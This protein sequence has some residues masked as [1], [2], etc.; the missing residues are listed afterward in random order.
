MYIGDTKSMALNLLSA[1][2]IIS[3]FPLRLLSILLVHNT[4]VS[5]SMPIWNRRSVVSIRWGMACWLHGIFYGVCCKIAI[6]FIFDGYVVRTSSHQIKVNGK[7]EVWN[8]SIICRIFATTFIH[9]LTRFIKSRVS[10]RKTSANK[11]P[12][13]HPQSGALFPQ[14]HDSTTITQ[15]EIQ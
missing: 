15:Q 13:L 12:Q 7:V 3:R 9:S 4:F 14:R 8:M 5:W 1:G 10:I 11:S 6:D 2:C